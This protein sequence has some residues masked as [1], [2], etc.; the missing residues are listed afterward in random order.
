MF[1]GGS[2]KGGISIKQSMI[3]NWQPGFSTTFL[4]GCGERTVGVGSCGGCYAF[5][6]LLGPGTTTLSCLF[7]V[8]PAHDCCHRVMLPVLGGVVGGGVCGGV[9]V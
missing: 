8:V 5:G 4:W 2:L 1:L 7:L 3:G 9:V 6:A